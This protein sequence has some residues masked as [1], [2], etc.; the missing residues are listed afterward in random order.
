M[1]RTYSSTQPRYILNLTKKSVAGV[2]ERKDGEQDKVS[3][4]YPRGKSD[5]GMKKIYPSVGKCR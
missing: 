1:S 4:N 5:R 2:K 3:L